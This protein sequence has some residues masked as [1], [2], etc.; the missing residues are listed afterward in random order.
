MKHC[1]LDWVKA[2]FKVRYTVLQGSDT[3][4]AQHLLKS[5]VWDPELFGRQATLKSGEERNSVNWG[6]HLANGTVLN[7]ETV[8]ES[9]VQT[10]DDDT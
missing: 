5:N 4:A 7:P 10:A 1:V 9:D 3:E 2:K 8:F 6:N